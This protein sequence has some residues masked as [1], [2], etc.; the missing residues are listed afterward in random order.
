MKNY[1]DFPYQITRYRKNTT[2]VAFSVN[3]R[4]SIVIM[5]LIQ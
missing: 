5:N 1:V 4:V 3:N 2:V